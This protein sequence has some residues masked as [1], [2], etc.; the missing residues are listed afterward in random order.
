M[1]AHLTSDFCS[2]T[3][4]KLIGVKSAWAWLKSSW[5][6]CSC[7]KDQRICNFGTLTATYQRI[8]TPRAPDHSLLHRAVHEIVEVSSRV[9]FCA[10]CEG[11]KVELC[12]FAIEDNAGR[13]CSSESGG[14]LIDQ[15]LE[16]L[17]INV[18]SRMTPH[19]RSDFLIRNGDLQRL[20]KH[21]SRGKK[22]METGR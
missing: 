8:P 20:A 21:M 16:D 5:V 4:L 2:V 6:R 22:G 1:S 12:I 14:L 7:D 3:P 17:R 11:D 19:L 18:L 10:A 9:A 13:L 15:G